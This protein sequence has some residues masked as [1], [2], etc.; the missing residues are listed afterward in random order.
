[1]QGM[2]AQL[3]KGYMVTD[4]NLH[5]TISKIVENSGFKHT[6]AFITPPQ[7]IPAEAKKPQPNPE[8]LKLQAGMQE[9]QAK[10]QSSEKQKMADLS[11]TKTT[12]EMKAG[13]Q[14]Y[15][16]ELEVASKER[17]AMM[18]L[19]SKERLEEKRIQ[20]EA[21]FKVFDANNQA[22]IKTAELGQAERLKAAELQSR[23]STEGKR[24][25]ASSKPTTTV[26]VNAEDSIKKLA[27]TMQKQ[28]EGTTKALTVAVDGIQKA[29]GELTKVA[30]QKP[31]KKVKKGSFNG[32]PFEFTE[33]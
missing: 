30:T 23:E 33:E 4:E 32:K 7:S 26:Q 11:V 17:I 14:R 12:E 20:A 15:I 31:G 25:E 1:L 5:M 10:L 24:I 13:I 28:G 2:L 8:M 27:E 16:A 21:Q 22:D 18:E 3:G 6:E 29:V 19:E 9:S